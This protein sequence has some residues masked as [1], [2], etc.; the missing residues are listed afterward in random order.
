MQAHRPRSG[1]DQQPV[2]MHYLLVG[3]AQLVR[4][5]IDLDYLCMLA[6]DSQVAEFL[7][8]ERE[9]LLFAHFPCQVISQPRAR[10]ITRWIIAD[11]QDFS[12]GILLTDSLGCR[13][14]GYP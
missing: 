8:A 6:L 12:L 11:H 7:R 3:Q 5:R 14:C 1:R 9:Q 10:V 13:N 2:V 4:L